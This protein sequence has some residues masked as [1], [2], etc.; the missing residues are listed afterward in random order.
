MQTGP[1]GIVWG[2]EARDRNVTVSGRCEPC[3]C[4][5]PLDVQQLGGP[6]RG[7]VQ[8]VHKR[9]VVLT[10]ELHARVRSRLWHAVVLGRQ[11]RRP[12]KSALRV[13]GGHCG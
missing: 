5:L 12:P 2:A 13:P 9:G 6:D 8:P 3:Q 7:S 11:R 4:D 1:R 10:P